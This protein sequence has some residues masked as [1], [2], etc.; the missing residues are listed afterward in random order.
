[1]N[2]TS[3]VIAFLLIAIGGGDAFRCY[4]NAFVKVGG[5]KNFW[6]SHIYATAAGVLRFSIY[7]VAISIVMTLSQA[8][9]W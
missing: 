1:M 8:F 2:T 4:A 6:F 9:G 7:F 3:H 5:M